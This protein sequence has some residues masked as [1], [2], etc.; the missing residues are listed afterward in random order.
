MKISSKTLLSSYPTAAELAA[1]DIAKE[2]NHYTD[3]GKKS[4]GSHEWSL[5]GFEFNGNPSF[6]AYA[7]AAE[8]KAFVVTIYELGINDPAVQKVLSTVALKAA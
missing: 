6:K 4:I 3:A 2:T 5:A 1:Y 7:D 8:G